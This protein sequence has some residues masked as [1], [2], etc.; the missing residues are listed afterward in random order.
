MEDAGHD[1][2][3]QPHAAAPAAPPA[4][5]AAAAAAPMPAP[6]QPEVLT[7]PDATPEVPGAGGG[8]TSGESGSGVFGAGAGGVR[9]SGGGLATPM[10]KAPP[11]GKC[12]QE[13]LTPP[14]K[15]PQAKTPMLPQATDLPPP[16]KI[17]P[18]FVPDPARVPVRLPP[19]LLPPPGTQLRPAPPHRGPRDKAMGPPLKAPPG[20]IPPNTPTKAP[21]CGSGYQPPPQGSPAST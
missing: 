1:N 6:P 11:L 4:A 17:P 9:T 18:N 20:Y 3:Y 2:G 13:F 10:E 12:A 16:S 21:P 19:N 5:P 15:L 14:P 8:E 7:P